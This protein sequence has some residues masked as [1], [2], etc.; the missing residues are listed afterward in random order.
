MHCGKMLTLVRAHK[1]LVHHIT[2]QVTMSECANIT[3]AAGG[4][5]I[6]AHAPEE[7]T[8]MVARAGALVLNIGTLSPAQ[9]EAMLLAGRRANE[10][11]IPIVLDPVGVG[12][13][14]FRTDSANRLLL[15]LR[16]AIIKGNAAEIAIL[17][18]GLAEIKGVESIAVSGDISNLAAILAKETGA[19]V[20]V[21]GAVDW[22]TDGSRAVA[23]HNG[24]VLMSKVV[25]TGCMTASVLGC[26]VSVSKDMFAAAVGALVSF[27]VAAE[28]A[29]QETS[30]PAAFK[31]ALF[32]AL[33]CLTETTVDTMQNIREGKM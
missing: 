15:N 8:E 30:A 9:I 10:L 33:F 25:G 5:P 1:P 28:I 12:A 2:N 19:V 17:A 6:M 11:G 29:A 13:T 4:L 32:D 16:I 14:S 22:V 27:N 23:V 7:V 31:V 24:H 26:F 3:L 21:T 20:V 18:G